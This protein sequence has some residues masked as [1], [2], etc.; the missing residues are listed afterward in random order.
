MFPIVHTLRETFI[1]FLALRSI[2]CSF[3]AIL[4]FMIHFP[5]NYLSP[6]VLDSFSRMLNVTSWEILEKLH[7]GQLFELLGFGRE[8]KKK[9][10][11]R[12]ESLLNVSCPSSRY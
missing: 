8:K 10:G 4:S 11:E 12:D 9:A 5:G 7:S 1:F 2:L 6:T 3:Q